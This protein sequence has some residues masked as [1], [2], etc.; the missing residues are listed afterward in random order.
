LNYHNF[1]AAI[2]IIRA[3]EKNVF[4]RLQYWHNI[5]TLKICLD[6]T[7]IWNIRREKFGRENS[8]SDKIYYWHSIYNIMRNWHFISVRVKNHACISWL[9]RFTSRSKCIYFTIFL[10]EL[11]GVCCHNECSWRFTMH[12]GVILNNIYYRSNLIPRL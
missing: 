9:I 10:C 12:N 4:V 1:T 5:Q 7:C 6:T 11:A 3:R 8:S 2:A